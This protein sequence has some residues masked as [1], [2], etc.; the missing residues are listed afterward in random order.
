MKM[1]T[2]INFMT[3][4]E[5]EDICWVK[6]CERGVL[7]NFKTTQMLLVLTVGGTVRPN[8]ML[9]L[10]SKCDYL[11]DMKSCLEKNGQIVTVWTTVC[12]LCLIFTRWVLC[13]ANVKQGWEQD[14]DQNRDILQGMSIDSQEKNPHVKTGRCSLLPIC[15]GCFREQHID[16]TAPP[17]ILIYNNVVYNHVIYLKYIAVQSFFAIACLLA[18][19]APSNIHELKVHVQISCLDLHIMVCILESGLTLVLDKSN[20]CTLIDIMKSKLSSRLKLVHF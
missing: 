14:S 10:Q 15:R 11:Y 1:F 2:N 12:I 8:N 17:K 13:S 9:S 7:A 5:D 3:C 20:V 19:L 16:L 4:P 6:V 18:C